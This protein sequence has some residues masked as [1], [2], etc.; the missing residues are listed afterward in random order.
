MVLYLHIYPSPTISPFQMS[1]Y[2]LETLAGA[3]AAQQDD[4]NA[5]VD[6]VST[7]IADGGTQSPGFFSKKFDA[8]SITLTGSAGMMGKS[9]VRGKCVSPNCT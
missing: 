2:N 4:E 9:S 8:R 3:F 7:Q 6:C 5:F 1:I